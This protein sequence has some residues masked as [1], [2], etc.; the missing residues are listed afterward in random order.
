MNKKYKQKVKEFF[1]KEGFY[2]VLF[3]CLCLVATVITI[4][5]KV[6]NK[7]NV[8]SEVT[9]NDDKTNNSLNKED[10]SKVTN[11][12]PNAEKVDKNKSKV[13][14]EEKV[15]DSDK[16]KTV[17]A[18]TEV[19]FSKPLEGTLL[20]GYTYPKPVRI[21]E[22]N[23]RTIRG[24]DVE[25]KVGTN[26]KAAAEGIVESAS[27]NGVEDGMTVVIAHVNGIKTKYTN[28]DSEVSVKKGDKVTA[29]TIIG[30]VGLT[31]KIYNKDDFGEHLNLQVLNNE[32][33][34]IDP[35]KYFEYKSE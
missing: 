31:A 17:T 29:S 4:S 15:Q 16:T 20:R 10:Q 25:A 30:K 32:N 35:L 5:Y 9:K 26:V 14:A 11:E 2:V 22:N 12:I 21:D 13:T 7:S 33:Q 8:Q 34:Q 18:T 19:K 1:R 3:L 24:I 6:S 27:N 28:L 23:Q